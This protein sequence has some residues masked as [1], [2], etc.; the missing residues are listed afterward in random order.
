MKD[1]VI[2]KRRAERKGM[3][4][5]MRLMPLM[6][7]YSHSEGTARRISMCVMLSIAKHPTNGSAAVAAAYRSMVGFLA[8]SE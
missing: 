7:K 2:W 6:C 4:H 5:F 8:S 3:S 1:A